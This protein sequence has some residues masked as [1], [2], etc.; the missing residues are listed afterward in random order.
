MISQA[1]NTI[2]AMSS[3][4]QIEG[5]DLMERLGKTW[6]EE[7]LQ[8]FA[9]ADFLVMTEEDQRKSWLK[10]MKDKLGSFKSGTGSV[11]GQIKVVKDLG[12]EDAFGA[13]YE[14][15]AEF[16]KAKVKVQV[17]LIKRIKAGGWQ[18]ASLTVLNE[19][20]EPDPSYAP[21]A[22]PAPVSGD[23]KP[24]DGAGKSGA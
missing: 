15:T 1:Q 20:G 13:V 4:A 12:G 24:V 14:N 17:Q 23:K 21:D 8:Y 7:D 16:E 18:M 5:D 6:S 10:K 19:K 9:S 3:E 2:Y 11:S 22:P